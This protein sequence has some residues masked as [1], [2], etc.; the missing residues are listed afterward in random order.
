MTRS[1]HGICILNTG[2][3][4]G[5]STAA[6]GLALRALGHGIKTVI[7]QFIKSG[8]TTGELKALAE[9]SP[10]AEVH[11]MGSGFTWQSD[12]EDVIRM[13]KEGWR[14]A[15]GKLADPSVGLLILDEITYPL[16]YGILSEDEVIAEFKK[17]PVGM[18]LVLTG[19]QASDSLIAM[20]DLVTE[21]REIKHPY[22]K[23]ITAQ[24]GIEF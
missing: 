23:G 20:A 14:L 10:L 17:R 9:F 7:I 18:H 13:A 15:K 1:H 8:T 6:F 11:V 4:K 2:N 5:K 19:R 21:M 12:R 24:K 3:G 16:N 22:S